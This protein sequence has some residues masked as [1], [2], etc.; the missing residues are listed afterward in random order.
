MNTF[1]FDEIKALMNARRSMR[2]ILPETVPQNELNEVFEVASIAPS[3]C[4]S[5]PWKVVVVSGERAKQLKEDLVK[6]IGQGDMQMD[7]PFDV[8]DY[9]EEE[10]KRMQTAGALMHKA[11]GISREDTESRQ[12]FM[13]KNLRFFGAPHA[14]FFFLPVWAGIRGAADLGMYAQN[15]MLAMRAKGIG[16]CPQT[17]LSFNADVVREHV[18]VSSDFQLLF[19]LSFGYFDASR[20]LNQVRTERAPL[21]SYVDYVS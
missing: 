6:T 9:P 16:S 18:G 17:I 12:N 11:A 7:V 2:E 19:G 14:A 10:T 1:D 5:Q 8:R 4:N 3:N 21:A 13:L 15:V 20:P